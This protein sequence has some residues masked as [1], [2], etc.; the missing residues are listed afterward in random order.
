MKTAILSFDDSD[1]DCCE[2]DDKR[3]GTYYIFTLGNICC[4]WTI[5]AISFTTGEAKTE[6]P[7]KTYTS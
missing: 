6:V 5:C 7:A 2:Y 1:G 3:V 4:E